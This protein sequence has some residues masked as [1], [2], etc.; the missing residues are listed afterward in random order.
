MSLALNLFVLF[1][2]FCV[3]CLL[4][5]VFMCLCS[6]Q[7][8]ASFMCLTAMKVRAASQMSSMQCSIKDTLSASVFFYGSLK[9]L[10]NPS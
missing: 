4:V 9:R 10:V 6:G 7:K 8:E 1:A 5:F 3:F 2:N